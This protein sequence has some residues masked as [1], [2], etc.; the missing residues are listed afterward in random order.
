[1][2]SG[3]GRADHRSCVTL[4]L[5]PQL[6]FILNGFPIATNIRIITDWWCWLWFGYQMP[7]NMICLNFFGEYASL[8]DWYQRET[9][10]Y[11][12]AQAE[13]LVSTAGFGFH[14][15]PSRL[16]LRARSSEL[17][18]RNG[19]PPGTTAICRRR[20]PRGTTKAEVASK[21]PWLPKQKVILQLHRFSW[22]R[23]LG[24]KWSMSSFT[25]WL[26]TT[27]FV[28]PV[29]NTPWC[30][31][32]NWMPTWLF[33]HDTLLDLNFKNEAHVGPQAI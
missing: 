4:S 1:M 2:T 11:W 14:N 17:D 13:W 24:S 23:M 3:Y 5:E 18:T 16:H 26:P 8:C 27:V 25:F 30:R 32:N 10:P 29:S 20:L 21:V 9:N 19:V 22:L 33:H 31:A 15:D 7:F 28:A 12:T 6:L